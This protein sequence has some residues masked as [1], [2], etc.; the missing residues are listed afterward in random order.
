MKRLLL[1]ITLLSGCACVK[2]YPFTRVE[3]SLIIDAKRHHQKIIVTCD[4]IR[5]HYAYS[6]RLSVGDT[7]I[8]S[9]DRRDVALALRT[10][11][12]LK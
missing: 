3:R 10:I 6:C 8:T 12:T 9:I 11:R 4:L 2:P 7:W 1:I 5:P